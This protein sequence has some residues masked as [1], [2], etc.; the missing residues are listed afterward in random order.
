LP[1]ILA[2]RPLARLLVIGTG[3]LETALR[4]QVRQAR[5]QQHVWF[6][7]HRHDVPALLDALDVVLL[8]SHYEGMPLSAIEAAAMAKPVVASDVDGVREVVEHGVTGCLVPEGDPDRLAHAVL[9]LLEDPARTAVIA[10]KAREQ[11]LQRFAIARQIERYSDVFCQVLDRAVE[12]GER[13]RAA[14]H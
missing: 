6:L 4:E 8:P 2:R 11:A 12:P 13:R 5:L 10:A 7:G 9:S 3:T 1:Q 14:E